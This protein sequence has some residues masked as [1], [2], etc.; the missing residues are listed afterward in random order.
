MVSVLLRGDQVT[1]PPSKLKEQGTLS[2]SESRHSCASVFGAAA[3]PIASV[4]RSR[5][6]LRERRLRAP[7][8]SSTTNIVTPCFSI[9][10]LSFTEVRES[11]VGLLPVKPHEFV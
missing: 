6:L 3:C 7:T 10:S 2:R 8:H 5:L 9:E 4:G 1:D 11:S